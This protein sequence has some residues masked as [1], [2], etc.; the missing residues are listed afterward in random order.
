MRRFTNQLHGPHFNVQFFSKFYQSSQALGKQCQAAIGG[1]DDAGPYMNSAVVAKDM[2]SFL[3]AYANSTYSQGVSNPNLLNF[4][5][6]SYGVSQPKVSGFP[7]SNIQQTYLGQVFANLFPNRVGRVVLDAVV[8][9]SANLA[10]HELQPTYADEAFST[11]FVYCNLAGASNCPYYTGSTASDILDRFE[12]TIIR[13]DATFAQLQGWANA[14]TIELTRMYFT[15][16]MTF[17]GSLMCRRIPFQHLFLL[18]KTDF[19]AY[20]IEC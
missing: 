18:I 9:A 2:T 17:R 19:E 4:W 1:P 12:A 20:V 6:F 3:E 15:G 7:R 16:F 5:G 10:G 14:T 11:F 8:D 13:L